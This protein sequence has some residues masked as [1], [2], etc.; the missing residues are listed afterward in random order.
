MNVLRQISVGDVAA[1][2]A[3]EATDSA[4][5]LRVLLHRLD[6]LSVALL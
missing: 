3:G 2:A 6:R 1:K 5:M 4:D